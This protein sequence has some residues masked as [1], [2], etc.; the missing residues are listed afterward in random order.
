MHGSLLEAAYIDQMVSRYL[1]GDV[2]PSKEL[3][4]SWSYAP[5]DETLVKAHEAACA[6]R[7][8]ASKELT[9]RYLGLFRIVWVT[10][11]RG[12]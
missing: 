5:A 9:S 4:A 12:E 7:M 3:P 11:A 10:V 2:S 8:P 6:T 1:G